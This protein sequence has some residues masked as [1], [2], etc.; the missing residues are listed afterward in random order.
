[1]LRHRAA[2]RRQLRTVVLWVGGL[3]VL[4]GCFAAYYLADHIGTSLTGGNG[5]T[6]VLIWPQF[7]AGMAQVLS[8]TWFY[9]YALG[10]LSARNSVAW[11]YLALFAAGAVAALLRRGARNVAVAYL[12][13][14]TI[15]I[16]LQNVFTA[17]ATAGW[18]YISIYPFVT[19]VAAYG[20]YGIALLVLR[21]PRTVAVA[22]GC[23]GVA[24]LA[25]DGALLSTYYDNLSSREPSFSAWS[26]AIYQLSRDLQ[27]TRGRVFTA[28]WGILD[29]LFALHPSRRYT[30]LA[31]RF[32]SPSPGAAK[33][34]Q[35]LL[36]SVSG[37]KL[38]VTHAT[39]ALVFPYANS[40][41]FKELGSYLRFAFAVDGVNGKPVYET[42]MYR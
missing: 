10:P 3:V 11:I 32:E 29:P 12:A 24:V 5:T 39:R 9:G 42:Y 2:V 35:Q 18:H 41:L 33:Q 36:A 31:F 13:L 7:R 15:L 38:I 16:A 22:L 1:M 23:V 14:V 40:S 25:Y 26:P 21:R 6:F 34:M 30:E 4:Y 19:I 20:A 28:D 37:P 27:R 17:Q 8:G